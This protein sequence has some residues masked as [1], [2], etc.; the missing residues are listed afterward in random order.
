MFMVERS[1]AALQACDAGWPEA[2]AILAK[3]VSERFGIFPTVARG[4][5]RDAAMTVRF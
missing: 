3:C 2:P 4:R 5:F 1:R